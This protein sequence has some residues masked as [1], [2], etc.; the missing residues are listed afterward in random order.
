MSWLQ[1]ERRKGK[2]LCMPQ[3]LYIS[4][5]LYLQGAP[6]LAL[7]QGIHRHSTPLTSPADG[8][9]FRTQDLP[10]ASKSCGLT[11]GQP[12]LAHS[13]MPPFT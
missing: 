5:S 3:G 13:L 7:D 12:R 8:L 1:T 6:G 9:G 4:I 10:G 2:L 11:M